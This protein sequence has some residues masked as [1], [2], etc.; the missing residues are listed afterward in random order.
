MKDRLARTGILLRAGSAATGLGRV[1]INVRD[2]D[3]TERF[4]RDVLGF[5]LSN[6]IDTESMAAPLHAVFMHANRHHHSLAFAPLGIPRRLHRR[7]L[8]VGA[9][10]RD[11]DDRT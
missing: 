6:H 8:E 7:M 9:E 4:Y 1:L 5:R 11:V 10:G 3:A 2:C